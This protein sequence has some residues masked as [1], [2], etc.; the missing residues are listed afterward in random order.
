MMRVVWLTLTVGI[1]AALAGLLMLK[2]GIRLQI[3]GVNTDQTV[4][5]QL[6]FVGGLIRIPKDKLIQ[7]KVKKEEKKAVS[8]TEKQKYTLVK[9]KE[10]LG[11]AVVICKA[12]VPVVRRELVIEDIQFGISAGFSDPVING[13]AFGTLASAV[14]LLQAAMQQTFI[15]KKSAFRAVP[16]FVSEEGIKIVFDITLYVRPLFL[17]IKC[18][19]V[20]YR[21]QEIRT[22]IQK[23]AKKDESE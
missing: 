8:D 23:Y 7:K 3:Y 12:A 19:K 13:M 11:D 4:D 18:I 17:L 20:W 9:I 6:R 10:L 2:E 5:Y 21:N 1:L 15:I 16:D 14:G 22:L